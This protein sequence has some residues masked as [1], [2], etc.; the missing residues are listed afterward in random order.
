MGGL[1]SFLLTKRLETLSA[2]RCD[3]VENA[4]CE[5]ALPDYV[6]HLTIVLTIMAEIQASVFLKPSHAKH[7]V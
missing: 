6:E 7:S 4:F 5:L 3:C 1:I 2:S